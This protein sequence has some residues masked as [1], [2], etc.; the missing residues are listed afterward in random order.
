VI[1][2]R[3]TFGDCYKAA[4]ARLRVGET[5][6]AFGSTHKAYIFDAGTWRV[7]DLDGL[8]GSDLPH[9]SELDQCASTGEIARKIVG[10]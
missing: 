6:V 8:R 5:E 10:K 9:I 4:S 1:A 7:V 2:P 3:A